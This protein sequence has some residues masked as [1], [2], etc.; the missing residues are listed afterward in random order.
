ML[1]LIPILRAKGPCHRDCDLNLLDPATIRLAIHA[2]IGPWIYQ[3]HKKRL[4]QISDVAS[5]DALRSADL[6]AKLVVADMLGALEEIL[7]ASA[8]MASEI[9]LLKGIS[10]CQYLYPEPHLRTM[11][12]VDLLIP[13]HSQQRIETLLLD[14]GYRQQS[15]QPAEFY[16]THHHS[17]P[18]FHPIKH[19]WVEIHTALLSNKNVASDRVFSSMHVE[20]QVV[21]ILFRG[22]KT[23]RLSYE[24]EMVYIAAH[25]AFERK[26][27]VGGVIPVL[28]M[29]YMIQKHGDEIDWD[30]LLP[31]LEGTQTAVYLNLI[32]RCLQKFGMIY[33]PDE[34]MTHIASTQKYPLGVNEAILHH[35]IEN[36]SMRGKPHGRI[37]SEANLSLLWDALLNSRPA[38]ANLVGA[39][40]SVLSA[41][42]N[43]RWFSPSFQFARISRILGRRY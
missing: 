41:S 5:R 18:F 10:T 23:N 16:K 26:C 9:I 43:P 4:S 8:D 28:D 11:G 38:W 33:L 37:A 30:H 12:D 19:Q 35:L 27:F 29:M 42:H 13:L 25:W 17:M 3:V 24:Q 7:A 36:Y 6:A 31:L 20:S 21:P 22:Y 14:L 39:L 34:L 32:L 15:S 1:G 2:G 40:W